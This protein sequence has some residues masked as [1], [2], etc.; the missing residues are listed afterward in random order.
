MDGGGRGVVRGGGGGGGGGLVDLD[1]V[2]CTSKSGLLNLF[3]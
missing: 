1:S 3:M 2:Y